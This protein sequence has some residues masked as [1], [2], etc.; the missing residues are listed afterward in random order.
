MKSPPRP[1]APDL[2]E[3]T[4]DP[5]GFSSWNCTPR[6]HDLGGEYAQELEAAALTDEKRI[7]GQVSEAKRLHASQQEGVRP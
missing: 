7:E 4:R 6:K 5:Q 2:I 1:T 3:I